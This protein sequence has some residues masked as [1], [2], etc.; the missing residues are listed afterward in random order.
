[1]GYRYFQLS[2]PAVVL[3]QGEDGATDELTAAGWQPAPW[4]TPRLASEN[5]RDPEK[6]SRRCRQRL[7]GTP[8]D[9][10]AGA[11]QGTLSRRLRRWLTPPLDYG[12]PRHF[13][14]ASKQDDAQLAYAE[15]LPDDLSGELLEE[16]VDEARDGYERQGKR[17]EGVERRAGLYQGG[18]SIS[19]GLV[20]T[21]TGLLAGKDAA[22]DGELRWA[23]LAGIVAVS[24]SL[25]LSGWRAHQAS[26]FTFSW[27]APTSGET[28]ASERSWRTSTPCGGTFCV[29]CSP[30]RTGDR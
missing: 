24:L 19:G 7:N 12:A 10:A 15:E 13:I 17:V 8:L 29:H 22:F 27:V 1:M 3:R 14:A 9:K 4:H 6:I 18:A 26:V 5:S 21:G 16:L 23:A 20:L 25:I 2:S 11:S 30:D 28:S